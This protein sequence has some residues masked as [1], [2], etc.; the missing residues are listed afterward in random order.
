MAF[1]MEH[2]ITEIC[3]LVNDI[4]RS[5]EFYQRLGFEME[6]HGDSFVSFKAAGLQLAVWDSK[7]VEKYVGFKAPD[8][9]RPVHK[10]MVA[11]RVAGQEIVDRIYEELHGKSVEMLSAPRYYPEWNAY[12]LYFS[13]PD[14]NTLE[15]YAWGEGGADAIENSRW[16]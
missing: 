10:A 8:S 6:R 4:E 5:I 11:F 12:C 1:G 13:D 3:L 9:D 16:M 15:V 2:P 7:Y 14:G